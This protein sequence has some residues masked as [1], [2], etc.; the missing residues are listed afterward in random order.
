MAAHIWGWFC[1]LH[2]E[3]GSNGMEAGRI[4]STMMKDWCWAS[5]N[6]LDLWERKA[7]RA[8]DIVWFASQRNDK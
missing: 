2:Q 5:G 4:T 3:R 7:I 6:T 1:E 8:V